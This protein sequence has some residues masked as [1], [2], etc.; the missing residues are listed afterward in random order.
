MKEGREGSLCVFMCICVFTNVKYMYE[1]HIVYTNGFM[2]SKE[3]E[4]H[5]STGSLIDGAHPSPRTD[6]DYLGC[7]CPKA[8][9]TAKG[10]KK[11]VVLLGIDPRASGL[12]RQ[13][14]ATNRQ[15]PLFL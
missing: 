9:E 8:C 15:P 10:K 1:V 12:S 6:R 2:M 7:Y 14:S 5:H 11:K 13:C 4:L 3:S